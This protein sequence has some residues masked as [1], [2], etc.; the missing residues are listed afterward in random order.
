MM[1]LWTGEVAADGRGF[2]V[3]GTGAPGSFVISPSMASK[4]PGR[5][6]YSPNGSECEWKSLRR[7]SGVP[8]HQVILSIDTTS[9]FG[10]IALTDR[11]L[12][13][14]E[15]LL[16]FPDGF[17]HILF[18]QIEKLLGEAHCFRESDGLLCGGFGAWFVHRSTDRPG[19]GEG[20][21]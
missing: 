6:E 16:H 4:F 10:S 2:R 7:G 20:A 19:S 17:G 13:V 14:E 21:G 5:T 8:A 11:D 18:P 3:L 12:V 1:Y 15:V 9:E